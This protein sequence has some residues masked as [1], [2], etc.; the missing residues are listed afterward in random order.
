MSNRT[1]LRSILNILS[2]NIYFQYVAGKA[3]LLP[4]CYLAH[5]YTY[6]K[7]FLWNGILSSSALA[8]STS[9]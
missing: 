5:L 9:I 6:V 1:L 7:Y 3:Q 2:I 4:M 8:L